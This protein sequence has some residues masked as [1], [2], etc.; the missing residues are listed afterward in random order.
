MDHTWDILI[1][2][3]SCTKHMRCVLKNF[4]QT[5]VEFIAW[6]FSLFFSWTS[7]IFLNGYKAPEQEWFPKDWYTILTT[8]KQHTQETWQFT[9]II[10]SMKRIHI[11]IKVNNV[12]QNFIV[13]LM[14]IRC[15]RSVSLIDNLPDYNFCNWS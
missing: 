13:P 7:I 14:R 2:L 5:I 1:H 9:G 11:F 12:Q 3:T 10:I 6:L 4:T 15:S 8:T